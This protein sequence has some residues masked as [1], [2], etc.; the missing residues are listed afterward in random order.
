MLADVC[1]AVVFSVVVW[2]AEGFAVEV[3]VTDGTGV[4]EVAAEVVSAGSGAASVRVVTEVSGDALT[5]DAVLPMLP[6]R[7]SGTEETSALSVPRVVCA[8]SVPDVTSVIP[9]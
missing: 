3:P 5:E 6:V 7:L 8:L 1:R 2:A 9:E 4:P